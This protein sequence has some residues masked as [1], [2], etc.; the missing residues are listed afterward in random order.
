M[1]LGPSFTLID[2]ILQVPDCN[3]AF[4]WDRPLHRNAME[5]Y[6]NSFT[7]D[8]TL[9]LLLFD[10]ICQN[11]I[12]VFFKSPYNQHEMSALTLKQVPSYPSHSNTNSKILLHD[13]YLLPT[14]RVEKSRGSQSLFTRQQN[15]TLFH[16]IENF[17][18][19]NR[20]V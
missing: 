11:E 20:R 6:I 8:L 10:L 19:E 16:F 13:A 17:G 15:F 18:R 1:Y 12:I 3:H 7:G 14:V 2:L 5:K 4:L 9:D